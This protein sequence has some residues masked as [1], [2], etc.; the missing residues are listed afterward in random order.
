MGAIFDGIYTT[1]NQLIYAITSIGIPFV[2]IDIAVMSFIIY[3]AIC[4]YTFALCCC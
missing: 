1:W 3:K 2:I 4:Y